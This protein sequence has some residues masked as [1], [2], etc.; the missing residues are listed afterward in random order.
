MIVLQAQTSE[1]MHLPR[2]TLTKSAN[3]P[4]TTRQRSGLLDSRGTLSIK[5][6]NQTFQKAEKFNLRD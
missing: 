4:S 3:S 6:G 1:K 2:N 5:W